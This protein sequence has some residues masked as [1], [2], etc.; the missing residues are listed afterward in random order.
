MFRRQFLSIRLSTFDC[1]FGPFYQFHLLLPIFQFPVGQ[2]LPCVAVSLLCRSFHLLL[3]GFHLNVYFRCVMVF[4]VCSV[5]VLLLSALTVIAGSS[6]SVPPTSIV[7][8]T[9]K[10]FLSFQ[11]ARSVFVKDGSSHTCPPCFGKSWS[12]S[13][14]LSSWPVTPRLLTTSRQMKFRLLA[15][16]KPGCHIMLTHL[17]SQS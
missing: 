15:Y 2:T 9:P 3:Q 17:L 4:T 1:S 13:S 12:L 10:S 5:N 11:C 16:L 8:T 14:V 6:K 7:G